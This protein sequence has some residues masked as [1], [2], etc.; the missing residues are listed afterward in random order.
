MTY[1]DLFIVSSAAVLAAEA[2]LVRYYAIAQHVH[3]LLK[4]ED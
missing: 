1:F 2:L 3:F 4:P